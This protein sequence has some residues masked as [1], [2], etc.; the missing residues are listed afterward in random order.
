ML[1]YILCKRR[2]R[3]TVDQSLWYYICF[4]QDIKY[5]DFIFLH[6]QG[7]FEVFKSQ[8]LKLLFVPTSLPMCITTCTTVSI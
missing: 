3:S 1:V 8:Y 2:F 4:L 6:F 5:V 7:C